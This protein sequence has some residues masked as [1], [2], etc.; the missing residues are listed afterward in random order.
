SV[1]VTYSAEEQSSVYIINSALGEEIQGNAPPKPTLALDYDEVDNSMPVIK[2]VEDKKPKRQQWRVYSKDGRI[3]NV[4]LGANGFLTR[5][6]SDDR[7][8]K[9]TLE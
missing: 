6:L 9:L 8:F 3:Q 7:T 2:Q 4:D 5:R 1:Y